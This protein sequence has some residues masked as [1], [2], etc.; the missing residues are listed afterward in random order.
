MTFIY[1][2]IRNNF[3]VVFLFERLNHLVSSRQA[4]SPSNGADTHIQYL[5]IIEFNEGTW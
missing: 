3:Y 2:T 1:V 5:V 4:N